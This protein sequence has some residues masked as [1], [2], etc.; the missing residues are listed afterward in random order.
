[1]IVK[2]TRCGTQELLRIYKPIYLPRVGELIEIKK[3][4]LTVIDLIHL[5]DEINIITRNA[6]EYSD[7]LK[8]RESWLDQLEK[9]NKIFENQ[10]QN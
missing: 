2:I 7:F 9:E 6:K 1:M 4:L 3:E 8:K 10:M 5:Q